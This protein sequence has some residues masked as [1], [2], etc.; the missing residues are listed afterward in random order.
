M[1]HTVPK[2]Y[3]LAVA[4]L[5]GAAL[6][7]GCTWKNIPEAP[8]YSTTE[9]IPIKI[10]VE[11]ESSEPSR[12]YGSK[13]VDLFNEMRVFESIV[14]PYRKGDAIDAV[15]FLSVKGGWDNKRGEN[16]ASG[17]F[18][19]GLA[20]ASMQGNHEVKATLR[21]AEQDIVSYTTQVSTKINWGLGADTKEVSAGAEKTHSKKMAID[22]AD[23]FNKDRTLILSKIKKQADKQGIS[24]QIK[25]EPPTT[26][27][28]KLDKLREGGVIS[29][30]EHKRAKEKITPA[31]TDNTDTD[32]KL[33][34]LSELQK[35][36]VLSE[37]DYNKAKKRLTELQKLNELRQNGVLTEEEYNKA[38]ARLMEK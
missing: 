36:G 25:A 9:A 38:K 4:F 35:S 29:E 26:D 20:G 11:L 14:F 17:F 5:A 12:Y 1:K 13:I 34:E 21:T 30:A 23:R 24:P 8:A 7:N 10:G 32:K 18:T 16:F 15:L 3:L 22:L 37:A 31:Q 28:E 6:L 2:S 27:T 33:Q 19:M